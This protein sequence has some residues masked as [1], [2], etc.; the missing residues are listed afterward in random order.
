MSDIIAI[1]FI[2]LEKFVYETAFT[3][4][5]SSRSLSLLLLKHVKNQKSTCLR[6][7]NRRP[8]TKKLDLKI[9]WLVEKHA[10]M[11]FPALD[12]TQILVQVT[13]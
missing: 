1:K 4:K 7:I 11:L 6:V 9:L 3:L 5:I 10:W 12:H 2:L 8:H 13:S